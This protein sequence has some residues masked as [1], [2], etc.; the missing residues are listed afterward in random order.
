MTT[1]KT[2]PFQ[3]SMLVRMLLEDSMSKLSARRVETLKE[4]GFYGDGDVSI[5]QLSLPVR[6]LGFCARSFKASAATLES[7]RQTLSL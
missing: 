4:P 1:T 5:Y 2:D 6:S 7:A 3:C